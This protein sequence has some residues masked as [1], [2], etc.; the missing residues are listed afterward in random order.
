MCVCGWVVDGGGREDRK[1]RR[2]KIGE[3]RGGRSAYAARTGAGGKARARAP[4]HEW[5]SAVPV[6]LVGGYELRAGRKIICQLANF[7][8]CRW[9]NKCI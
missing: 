5:E 8:I 2:E 7:C 3:D 9:A 1:G 6:V 4:P